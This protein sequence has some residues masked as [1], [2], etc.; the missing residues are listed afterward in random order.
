MFLWLAIANRRDRGQNTKDTVTQASP[1]NP[2]IKSFA[3]NSDPSTLFFFASEEET[4][5]RK[6]R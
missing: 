2:R 3:G 6:T 1:L 4:P 5:L